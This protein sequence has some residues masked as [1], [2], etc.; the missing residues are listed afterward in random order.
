MMTEPSPSE[1]ESLAHA[2]TEYRGAGAP[3]PP[4]PA[5]RFR[6]ARQQL[7]FFP[8]LR[9]EE[10]HPKKWTFPSYLD[11]P[12]VPWLMVLKEMYAMPLA[13]PAS[14]SPEAGL[15]LHALVRSIKPRAIVEVGS[16]LGVSTIWM[17]AALD[18]A[19]TDPPHVP[20]PAGSAIIHCFDDFGP[21][22]KAKWR[23]VELDQERVDLVRAN[24]KKAGL[25]HLVVLHPGD[26]SVE[27]RAMWDQLRGPREDWPS[28]PREHI[29]GV[30]FALIDGNHSVEGVL[31]DFWAIEPVLNSGGYVLLHDT[32]PEQCGGY[33]GPRHLIDQIQTVAQGLYDECELYTAPLNY[34]MALL[35]R[36]G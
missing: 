11:N 17:A 28:P 26:S 14:F 5:N 30:D 19:A 18:A 31:Q 33:D 34:G 23:D 1:S 24:L 4:I 29:G 15:L 13:F 20:S 36:V 12:A 8:M 22:A 16:F 10:D 2:K 27:I 6:F 25:E 7:R 35:R 9:A 21:V 3:P 32:F